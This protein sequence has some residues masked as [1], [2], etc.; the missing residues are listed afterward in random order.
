M[1]EFFKFIAR[2]FHGWRRKLG[3][4]TLA[5]ACVFT[6]GW[7]RSLYFC[8][9]YLILSDDPAFHLIYSV[10]NRFGW[11]FVK[12][13]GGIIPRHYRSGERGRRVNAA[14]P[15][16]DRPYVLIYGPVE[17]T[18]EVAQAFERGPQWCLPYW[19]IVIPLTL[20]SAYLLLSK[21]RSKPAKPQS[22]SFGSPN[23]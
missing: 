16:S 20:L 14:N 5:M 11:V 1:G 12:N 21:P 18:H 22:P 7:M 10:P 6:L 17:S 13:E 3:V 2:F 15:E 8:N 9:G 4:M 23:P 19:S